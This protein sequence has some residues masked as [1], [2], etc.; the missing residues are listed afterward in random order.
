METIS[1]GLSQLEIGDGAM[2]TV[3]LVS[4]SGLIPGQ[5]EQ[6]EAHMRSFRLGIGSTDA[7]TPED[8][9]SEQHSSKRSKMW[10]DDIGLTN[11][12]PFPNATAG[13]SGLSGSTPSSGLSST[14]SMDGFKPDGTLNGLDMA[15]MNY[16]SDTM[17]RNRF[18]SDTQFAFPQ[19]LD[20][21]GEPVK[22]GE[23]DGNQTS[24]TDFEQF[25][26]AWTDFEVPNTTFPSE[27]GLG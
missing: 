19:D 14:A 13:N 26:S 3:N 18:G 23:G 4:A 11:L 12:T 25:I 21:A 2:G 9:A 8:Y 15:S 27:E 1:N 7:P 6:H 10:H 20:I 24:E 17:D 22:N 5:A 16:D